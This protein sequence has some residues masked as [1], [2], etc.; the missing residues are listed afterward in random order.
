MGDIPR[1][2][3]DGPDHHATPGRNRCVAHQAIA[4]RQHNQRRGPTPVANH[5]RTA[6]H[7][8]GYGTCAHCHAIYPAGQLHVDHRTP[9]MHGGIDT[10]TNLQTLC[11]VCHYFKT[12]DE[13]RDE[14][15]EAGRRV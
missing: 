12:R 8:N 14:R 10:I 3:L 15:R 11:K 5:A 13:R 1:P 9:L 4:D 6:L 2:C 7:R